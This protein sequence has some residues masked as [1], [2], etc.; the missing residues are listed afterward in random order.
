[1][2]DVKTSGVIQSYSTFETKLGE[3]GH[4]SYIHCWEIPDIGSKIGMKNG[5]ALE[6][7]VFTIKTNNSQTEWQLKL[8]PNGNDSKTVGYLSLFLKRVSE[9]K[10]NLL[11]RYGFKIL[12]DNEDIIVSEGM[13]DGDVFNEMSKSWGYPEFISHSE[14]KDRGISSGNT[15][16]KF[17][18]EIMLI[19][20][21]SMIIGGS[22]VNKSLKNEAKAV[23]QVSSHIN[24]LY[25][26]GKY[27][28]CIVV[29]G[30]EV[31]KCHKN[32][33]A[34]RSTV[35]DAMLSH[36][37]EEKKSGRIVIED[38][39]VDIVQGMLEFIYS[40][41]V[42]DI[43]LKSSGL[44]A[45]ADKYDLTHLKELCVASLCSNINCSNVLDMLVLAEVYDEPTLRSL[46]LEFTTKNS[47]KI[48]DLSDWKLKLKNHPE[49]FAEMY[50]SLAKSLEKKY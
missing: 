47:K 16:H 21:D 48:L 28:D 25:Q 24:S 18:V 14:F 31:F 46:S 41:H 3:I 13:N 23:L 39:D 26:S 43:K 40:G 22:G 44:L 33:L 34:S 10:N 9:Y 11:V 45:A 2:M 42:K 36:E 37:M 38:L 5:E 8:F 35:F 29:C 17:L 50:E 49:L 4:R 30:D 19:G 27:S 32:I 20:D 12:D 1:M 15:V 6:S 7:S